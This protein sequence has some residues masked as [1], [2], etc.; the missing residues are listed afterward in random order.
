MLN[1]AL[2]ACVR[3]HVLRLF[4]M[5]F[6]HP[7]RPFSVYTAESAAGKST[8]KPVLGG[9]AVPNQA[10]IRELMGAMLSEKSAR[11][12]ADCLGD[13]SFGDALKVYQ[14]HRQDVINMSDDDW[15]AKANRISGARQGVRTAASNKEAV[16]KK[17][18]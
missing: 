13:V 8:V 6:P 15:L 14:N 4:T 1:C 17:K 18:K 9:H 10:L 3:G 12:I 2:R 11:R 16:A 5:F 7:N